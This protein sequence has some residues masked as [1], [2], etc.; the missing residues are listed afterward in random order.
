MVSKSGPMIWIRP[1]GRDFRAY[2][3]SDCAPPTFWFLAGSPTRGVG[4]EQG[5]NAIAQ[6]LTDLEHD[7]HM[8][9]GRPC[10]RPP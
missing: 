6:S 5:G 7:T 4:L 9:R 10:N 1:D 2:P 8:I 3:G